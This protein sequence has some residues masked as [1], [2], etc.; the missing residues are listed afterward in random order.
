MANK[1]V[2]LK[3]GNDIL[4][5][6]SVLNGVDFD[7]IIASGVDLRLSA[8]Y[9]A[10]QDCYMI[11]VTSRASW[12]YNGVEITAGNNIRPVLALKKGQEVHS[13]SANATTG[14]IYGIL[15]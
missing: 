12:Y 11:P 7:N 4:Y 2:T 5:P 3:D 13:G 8:G 10:T 14:N 1:K 6:Q 15:K 9:T